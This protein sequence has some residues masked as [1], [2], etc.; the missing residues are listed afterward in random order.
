MRHVISAN[1]EDQ[2]AE[3][4]RYR[5]NGE[6]YRSKPVGSNTEHRQG[7][8]GWSHRGR[9]DRRGRED[10]PD[11]APLSRSSS[12]STEN[13]GGLEDKDRT[14][15][16]HAVLEC[17]NPFRRYP[18]STTLPYLAGSVQGRGYPVFSLNAINIV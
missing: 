6:T 11:S 14:K 15:S 9:E 2:A 12:D 4:A 3:E 18:C 13:D 16:T 7:G 10:T 5:V 17:R 8:T 1:E